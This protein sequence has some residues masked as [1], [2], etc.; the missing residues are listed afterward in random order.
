[1]KKYGWFWNCP[2]GETCQYRHAL[3]PG[4]VLKK[5][6][7]KDDEKD[8][9]PLEELIEEQRSN[10]T[11]HTPLT[12][13]LFLEWKEKKHLAKEK[14]KAETRDKRLAEGRSALSGREMFALNPDLFVDDDSAMESSEM[15]RDDDD[16][17]EM[18]VELIATG[19]SIV[20]RQVGGGSSSSSSSAAAAA[21][22]DISSY[23]L[24]TGAKASDIVLVN[25]IPVDS[26]LFMS[27]DGVPEVE[28]E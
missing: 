4:F 7:K 19:T 24:R 11:A 17:Q 23:S 22:F 16:Q 1:M 6:K 26:S 8:D 13:E 18:G 20:A 15:K 2:N 12:L 28:F 3:P 14:A 25:G 10:L 5:D 21:E 27:L 9:T